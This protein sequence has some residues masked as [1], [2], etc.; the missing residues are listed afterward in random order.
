MMSILNRTDKEM[1]RPA[2]KSQIAEIL[3]FFKEKSEQ[4]QVEQRQGFISI[5]FSGFYF[6]GQGK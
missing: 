1:R 2:G 6:E 5:K 4:Q 3:E